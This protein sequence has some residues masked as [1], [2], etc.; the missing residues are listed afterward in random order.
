ML[1]NAPLLL[2]GYT[3]NH[4]TQYPRPY[5]QGIDL[6]NCQKY[7]ES[8]EAWEIIWREAVDPHR[9]YYQALIQTAAG[10][11]HY[12]RHNL[13]GTNLCINN[14]LQKFRR[15]PDSFMGLLVPN[16]TEEISDF[17]ADALVGVPNITT[18]RGRRAARV[19]A[20]H[21]QIGLQSA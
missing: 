12:D 17:V 16:F 5:L 4:I 18:W 20:P 3:E 15:L 14:A 2:L 21:P 19:L 9:L 10:L 13:Y 8:H 7:W 11:L 6:F 1:E